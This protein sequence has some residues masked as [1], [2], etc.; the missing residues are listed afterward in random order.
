M[1][2]IVWLADPLPGLSLEDCVWCCPI[3]IELKFLTIAEVENI[4]H[5]NITPKIFTT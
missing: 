4:A 2:G 3:G 5:I 1:R